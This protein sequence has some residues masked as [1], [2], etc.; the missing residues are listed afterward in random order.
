MVWLCD[1]AVGAVDLIKSNCVPPRM[2]T[3]IEAD[4]LWTFLQKVDAGVALLDCAKSLAAMS[5]DDKQALLDWVKTVASIQAQ[6][7]ANPP[8]WPVERPVISEWKAFK[9]LMEAF[10]E[11]GLKSGLPYAADGSPV[12]TGGVSYTQFVKEFREAHRLSTHPSAREVCVLC[13]GPLGATPE[14]DHWVNKSAYPL[15]S[16]CADNLLPVCG[17]CNSSSNKGAKPVHSQGGFGVWFHPYLRHANDGVSL[18]YDTKSQSVTAVAT[19][20]CD[21]PKVDNLDKLLN[22]S[23]RWTVEFKAEYSKQQNV[24]LGR[25]KR[26]KNSNQTGQTQSDIIAHIQSAQDDLLSTEP[27]FEV[28]SALLAALLDTARLTAWQTELALV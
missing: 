6:F 13:G 23:A 28:H 19:K 17:D 15:L 9:R 5:S 3:Q 25:E 12:V 14:V 16:V 26:R 1:P 24:L 18:D 11:K 20:P 27:H 10:Y 21:T 22:L 8:D 2:P 7:Q 4:W